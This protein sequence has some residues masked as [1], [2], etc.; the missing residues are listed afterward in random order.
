[1]GAVGELVAEQLKGL[2]EKGDKCH[3]ETFEK[4]GFKVCSFNFCCLHHFFAVY[5]N[6]KFESFF[7]YFFTVFVLQTCLPYKC[8]LIIDYS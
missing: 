2:V 8:K 7:C 1:M 4:K 6:L 3:F 5:I